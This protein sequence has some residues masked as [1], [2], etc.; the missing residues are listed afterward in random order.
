ML[1]SLRDY[2]Q[3][4]LIWVVVCMGAPS[5]AWAQA[6]SEPA[7]DGSLRSG[8]V[9]PPPIT[10][11]TRYVDTNSLGGTCSDAGAGTLTAPWC[12]LNKAYQTVTA[13]DGVLVRTGTYTEGGLRPTNNGTA[14]NYITFRA[15]PGELPVLDCTGHG[16]CID[17]VGIS[18]ATS[19]LV[20]DGIEMTNAGNH[21]INC[22]LD[23]GGA[24]CHH[25]W[26]L[27]A[28][29]HDSQGATSASFRLVNGSGNFVF[30][31]NEFY[32]TFQAIGV[33]NS[34]NTLIEFNLFHDI[35]RNLDDDAPAKCLG[36]WNCVMRYNTVYNNWRNPASSNPCFQPTRC[37]GVSGLYVDGGHD[38]AHGS[39]MSYV[40]NNVVYDNDIGIQVFATQGAR[41]FNN[42]VYHNG[43]TAGN[44]TFE[45]QFGMGISTDDSSTADIQIYNNTVIGNKTVGLN[46]GE[47]PSGA[48]I[49]RNNLLMNNEG[50][51]VRGNSGASNGDLDYDLIADPVNGGDVIG[52]NNSTYTLATFLAR[53]GNTTWLHAV[54]T[55]ATF[56]NSGAND[57]HLVT[58]SSAK[59][60]GTSVGLF[61][62][63]KDNVARPQGTL[64]DIG[65]YEFL[66]GGTVPLVL[67]LVR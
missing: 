14:G 53:G 37:Q 11:S 18:P 31:N 9:T 38:N 49:S 36:T 26:F 33:G 43:F 8:P 48:V 61:A 40:Y 34:P 58:G 41:I 59:E 22:S 57:Y 55:A 32:N 16:E 50:L 28:K 23:L 20:W 67:R 66:A 5:V 64:W 30:S 56:V 47:G 4:L 15:Y 63:D 45:I 19:Y 62:Y 35:G 7:Y 51:E 46:V 65:A 52:W 60:A 2:A 24:S 10:G 54:S 27:N 29:L 42:I 17:V 12:T 6:W 25:L 21:I 13:G 3:R 44:G 39:A 1:L